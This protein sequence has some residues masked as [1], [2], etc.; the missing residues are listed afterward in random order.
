MNSCT[1]DTIMQAY[2]WNIILRTPFFESISKKPLEIM[3]DLFHRANKYAMLED[4]LHVTLQQ[5]VTTSP[6]SHLELNG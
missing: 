3:D 6:V 5:I 1:M 2:K 4:D